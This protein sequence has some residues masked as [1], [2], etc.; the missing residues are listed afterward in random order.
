[1]DPIEDIKLLESDKPIRKEHYRIKICVNFFDK[2]NPVP[3]YDD[4]ITDKFLINK[5]NRIIQIINQHQNILYAYFQK[6]NFKE[7]YGII[8]VIKNPINEQILKGYML[9]VM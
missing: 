3:F 4:Q 7:E 1:M 6:S 5:I 2:K 9:L 8:F